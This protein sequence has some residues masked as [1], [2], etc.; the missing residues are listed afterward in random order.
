M[1]KLE[2][3]VLGSLALGSCHIV[4]VQNTPMRKPVRSHH[5]RAVSTDPFIDYMRRR[6]YSNY[7]DDAQGLESTLARALRAEFVIEAQEQNIPVSTWNELQRHYEGQGK[8]LLAVNL[9]T[10]SGLHA[11]VMLYNLVSK[12][13]RTVSIDGR[14]ISFTSI[15][16]DNPL[17]KDF[18]Y[19]HSK[20]R[21]TNPSIVT[22]DREIIHNMKVHGR[23]AQL[24]WNYLHRGIRP[25]SELDSRLREAEFRGLYEEC[26]GKHSSIQA[27]EREFRR[28]HIE[29]T[30]EKTT[31]HEAYHMSIHGTPMETEN[32]DEEVRA[33]LY[34]Y[35]NSQLRQGIF[36][37][38]LYVL[39]NTPKTSM[40]HRAADTAL[41]GF[42]QY[43]QRG[44]RSGRF[45]N[46]RTDGDGII[47]KVRDFH[48]LT[49]AEIKEISGYLYRKHCDSTRMAV[50]REY[51]RQPNCYSSTG[52]LIR[53]RVRNPNRLRGHELRAKALN[54]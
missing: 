3:L 30:I 39:S 54:Q 14:N 38:E 12:E 41:T 33:I 10:E 4:G 26:I 42:V 53:G 6:A 40:H 1:V 45:S 16:I 44:H 23:N 27:A 13:E 51:E 18:F 47:E 15:V 36:L 28:R 5:V 17:I 49:G 20:G 48:N 37:S 11:S 2:L 32:H 50:A 19:Y 9:R 35:V 29:Q 34:S 21:Y 7:D 31:S 43:I 22:N 52:D 8:Y 46:I 25:Y 24:S